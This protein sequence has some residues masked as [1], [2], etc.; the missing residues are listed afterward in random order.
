MFDQQIREIKVWTKNL[1]LLR[2][3]AFLFGGKKQ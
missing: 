2:K 1:V 3:N